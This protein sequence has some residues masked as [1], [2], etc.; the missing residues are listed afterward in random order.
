MA[1]VTFDTHEF[2]KRLKAVGFSDE[3]AEAMAEAR[4]AALAQSLD[5][6]LATKADIF[7]V[8]QE[9]ADVRADVRLL[10]WMLGVV[11]GG[12][13]ALLLKAFFPAAG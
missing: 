8:R 1:T 10:K 12:V 9:L 3:Q 11:L 13:V 7:A 5:T 4:K 2:I 6:A